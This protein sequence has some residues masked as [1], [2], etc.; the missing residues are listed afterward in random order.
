MFETL[1]SVVQG[2]PSKWGLNPRYR[3]LQSQ[4]TVS[5]TLIHRLQR[6]QIAL[7]PDVAR[8]TANGVQFS[9]G[10]RADN[11]DVVAMCTGFDI[12]LPFFDA[13]T[14]A[15]VVDKATNRMR[16]YESVF[17]PDLGPSLAFI[18]FAQPASGG[19]L[20][21]SEIQARWFAEV[22]AGRCAL[23]PP[24]AMQAHMRKE[25]QQ[26]EQ[27]YGNS[28]RHTI[29]RDP[30]TYNDT[31]AQHFGARPSPWRAMARLDFPLAYRLLFS[32]CSSA[33]WRL[34]GPNAWPGA[35][36]AVMECPVTPMWD[37]TA[38]LLLA[39]LLLAAVAVAIRLLL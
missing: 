20:S 34:R 3:A 17:S 23:P 9:D 21:I 4:P 25:A 16:L 10:S 28:R 33:Q 11:V 24:A 2:S 19:L 12:T 15:T 8:F 38:K 18:G 13:H 32:S 39:L 5:P 27:R 22:V 31:V 30:I 36:N 1:L 6:R 37:I 35:R 29:Q 7:R 14:E 26:M